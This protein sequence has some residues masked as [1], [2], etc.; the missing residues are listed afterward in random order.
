MK[1]IIAIA[2]LLLLFLILQCWNPQIDKPPVTGKLEAPPEVT[3]IL[4]R[5]CADCHSNENRLHWYDEI[6][7]A[8]S[9]KQAARNEA[10]S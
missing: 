3:A 5:A 10:L 1:V 6:A 2:F 8:S 4:D 7:P 9:W